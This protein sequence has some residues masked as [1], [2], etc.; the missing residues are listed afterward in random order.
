MEIKNFPCLN[1]I[2]GNFRHQLLVEILFL[3]TRKCITITV[4]YAINSDIQTSKYTFNCIEIF[5]K[6]RLV[7]IPDLVM[8][9]YNTD[10]YAPY[11]CQ[12]TFSPTCI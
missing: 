2:Y 1:N 3:L 10:A 7:Q 8:K 4:L 9:N 12:H 11:A 6:I 5:S